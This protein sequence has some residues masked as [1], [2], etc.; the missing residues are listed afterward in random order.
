MVRQ[1]NTL[2][3]HTGRRNGSA[4]H[5]SGVDGVPVPAA[6]FESYFLAGFECSAHR[7]GD[8][9]RLDLLAATGHD[10]RAA[11]DYRRVC[12][13]GLRTV[14]DGVRWH[15]IE[16]VPGRYDWSSALPMVRAAREAGVQVVWDLCH[17]GWPDDLD[18]FDPAFVERFARFVR[19]FARLL[20]DETDAPPWIVPIN[21][22]SFLAW[23][24]GDVGYLNPFGRG[25]GPELK[26]QL[27]RAA[28]AAI[29]ALWAV[30]PTARIVHAEP[31]INVVA[32]PT[33]PQDRA[34]A[35]RETL[36]QYDTWD[37]LAGRAAPQ[38]GGDEKYLDVLG[39]NYYP[40]NQWW[41]RDNVG[42]NPDLAIPRAHPL[43]RPFRELLADVH[44]RY[45]RPFF[46]AE[47]GAGDRERP[48]WLRYVGD[49]VRAALRAGV[50]VGGICLYP[51][52]NFPWWDDDRHLYNGL[53]DYPPADDGG[54][55]IYQPLADELRHQQRLFARVG[56]GGAARETGTGER[57][58]VAR[59]GEGA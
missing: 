1:E 6:L 23:G 55:A 3:E 48:E 27:V 8:G 13:L 24:G 9:T 19:A 14:R 15:L 12:E 21:E 41:M 49:E 54:R 5:E 51:I 30:W 39:V 22:I 2:G 38:L 32:D 29:E 59:D 7:R 36:A 16:R 33:S 47:T 35:A 40:H 37:L 50:P 52:I 45:R 42:F 17:Y 4:Q 28:I 26:A 43:Y 53:L 56:M 46:I 31:I 25:R 58:P 10:R 18:P 57:T 11:E 20:A 44:E 34:A